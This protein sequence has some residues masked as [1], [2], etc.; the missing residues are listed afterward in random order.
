[1]NINN[2]PYVRGSKTSKAA[3][4]YVKP[5]TPSMRERIYAYVLER[6]SEGATDWEI[7]KALNLKH[8]SASARR[9][10]L[11]GCGSLKLT[12][13]TRPTES[14]CE[15]GVYV[16]NPDRPPKRGRPPKTPGKTHSKKVSV[17]FT[18]EQHADLCMAA[19]GQGVSP[20]AFIRSAVIRNLNPLAGWEE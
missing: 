16:A 13:D 10:E 5:K 4:D 8:Q 18:P 12:E 15:A 17:Y 19:A 6:G 2:P 3:A 9:F 7:E 1:M 11:V 20:A 14:G